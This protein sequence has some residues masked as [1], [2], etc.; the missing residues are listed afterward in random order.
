M[1]IFVGI[2]C[3]QDKQTD[4]WVNVPCPSFINL[5]AV[6]SLDETYTPRVGL[7][8]V[9]FVRGIRGSSSSILLGQFL[10]WR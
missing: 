2:R 3:M 8:A 7:Y 10:K 5:E 4:L 1:L 6:D 9:S